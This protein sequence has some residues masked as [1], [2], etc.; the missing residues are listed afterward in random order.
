MRRIAEHR[1]PLGLRRV[2]CAN[3]GANWQF[4]EAG[5][6]GQ[7]TDFAQGGLQI[8][9]DIIAQGLERRDVNHL[10]AI[11]ELALE[12]L[13]KEP[14]DTDEKRRQRLSRAGWCGDKRMLSDRDF[15]P[16]AGL[17]LRRL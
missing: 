9:L 2:A 8:S 11:G 3:G 7:C 4:T 1:L 6:Y 15:R 13:V 10:D 14:I 12:P 17:R 5:F 16:A